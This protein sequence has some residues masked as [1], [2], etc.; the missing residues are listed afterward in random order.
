M[1]TRVTE[2]RTEQTY[3][4]PP[5]LRT[6]RVFHFLNYKEQRICHPKLKIVVCA[7][8]PPLG[9]FAKTVRTI[10]RI[11]ENYETAHSNERFFVS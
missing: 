3:C 6:W 4:F 8:M 1:Q 7:A 9:F 10:S 2:Q 5:R 11:L